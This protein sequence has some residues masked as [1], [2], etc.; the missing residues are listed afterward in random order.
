[1]RF[2][3]FLLSLIFLPI[4][5]FADQPQNDPVAKAENK[6]PNETNSKL[7]R[8]ERLLQ[9][10]VTDT[11]LKTNVNYS[12]KSKSEQSAWE[13]DVLQA[14]KTDDCRESAY[15]SRILVLSSGRQL[16][17]Q[18]VDHDHSDKFTQKFLQELR[19][20]APIEIESCG[21]IINVI[22][23]FDLGS[24]GASSFGISCQLKNSKAKVFMCDDF[25]QGK[26][27][28]SLPMFDDSYLSLSRYT[29][30]T[31]PPGG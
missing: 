23:S 9:V 31:C 18:K 16:R 25:Y 13:K 2:K 29:S 8:L 22:E 21:N 10:Q 19:Q 4:Y 26:F 1:M 20:I 27:R 6:K 24:N 12:E 5:C 3:F 28:V 11:Y 7:Q 17:V 15:V 14:C 30:E